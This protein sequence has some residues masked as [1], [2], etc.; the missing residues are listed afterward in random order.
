M[1]YDAKCK[2]SLKCKM[3]GIWKP[4]LQWR[5]YKLQLFTVSNVLRKDSSAGLLVE[6]HQHV[7]GLHVQGWIARICHPSSIR[8]RVEIACAAWS[9]PPTTVTNSS[10][11]S[12]RLDV[13]VAVWSTELSAVWS[14]IRLHCRCHRITG[15]SAVP[16]HRQL[17]LTNL[18][19]DGER[20]VFSRVPQTRSTLDLCSHRHTLPVMYRTHNLP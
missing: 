8:A 6:F 17:V 3:F 20:R 2:F 4:S 15:V 1:S 7:T 19:T 14:S 13:V 16:G 10:A 12:T 18:I 9:I 5:L 11:A